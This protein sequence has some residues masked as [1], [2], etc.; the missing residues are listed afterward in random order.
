M[1]GLC[2]LSL[3]AQEQTAPPLPLAGPHRPA[4][5]PAD[6]VITPFGY[7]HPSCVLVLKKGEHR[8]KDGVLHHADGSETQVAPCQYPH[9]NASG[10]PAS[11]SAN[12]R[13]A[14]A[15]ADE[16]PAAEPAITGYV[17][18]AS[19]FTNTSYG[20]QVTTWTV[21]PVPLMHDGQTIFIWPGFQ[22]LQNT[23]SVL[24]PVI[25][26]YN[27]GQWTMASWN[28]CLAGT[29]DESTPVSINPGDAIM[30][31]TEMTCAAGTVTCATWN[32]IIQDL[33]TNQS[34]ELS[35][36][37][38][39]GQTFNWA[40]GGVV[41]VYSVF[42]CYDYPPN[43]SATLTSQLYD[44]NLNL[45]SSPTW[46]DGV[47]SSIS[48]LQPQCNYGVTSTPTQTTLTYGTTGPG[49]GLSGPVTGIAVNQ[50]S[51]ASGTIGITAINGFN[52][53][54]AMTVSNPPTGVTAQITQGSSPTT[55]TLTVTA[56]SAAALTGAN[57][58]AALT[59]TAS[60]PGV[61]TE[62][63]PLNVIVNPPLTGGTGTSVN[64]SSAYNVDG[65]YNDSNTSAITGGLDAIGDVYSAN[66]LSPPG[67]T[68]MGLDFGG[69]QFAFGPP[70]Q[71]DSV[72]GSAAY[73][74]GLPS[75][76]F[77]SL[78]VL[79]TGVNGVQ[80][81]Q[82]VT[83]TY[84]DNATQAFT[85]TFDDWYSGASCTST[86]PCAS[87]ESVADVMPY[88]DNPGGE[89]SGIY[90][91]Y[92]YS[93]PLNSSKTV[94]SLTL[95]TNRKVV[96]LA[97][98]LTNTSSTPTFSPAAGTYTSVQMVTLG[99]TTPAATIYY[100]TN[101]TTPTTASAVYSGPITVSSTTAIQAIA[102]AS[103]YLNSPVASATYTVNIPTA[104]PTFSPAGGTYA[105]VQT[106]TLG[107][108]TPAATIYY[109][110][111]G[112]TPTTSSAVYSGPI[113]VS[114]TTTI[115]AIAVASGYVTSAL[116]SATYTIAIP[117]FS[118]A[119][120]AVTVSPGT[121]GTSTLTIS[122]TNGYAGTVTLACSITASPYGAADIPTCTATPAITLSAT[123]S[124]GTATVAVS[125]T[126][127][128]ASIQPE[129]ARPDGDWTAVTGA[130]L[131]LV[132]LPWISKR[133]R[134]WPALS[135]L[136]F[137]SLLIGSLLGCSSGGAGGGK[138]PS[139]PGTTA[140]NYTISVTG[141]GSDSAHT[142]AT[143]TFTLTVN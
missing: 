81:S 62:T 11:G 89:N 61:A 24:Q 119:A 124:S 25:G 39:D 78:N 15:K 125:S 49:F 57:Q 115:Q 90:Y 94:K 95:P 135:I 92:E 8:S 17:E 132:V 85:Q 123:T 83:V 33:T 104:T 141:T 103:G 5:V 53:S 70:N 101:G 80:A 75:G 66:Q 36:T 52:G 69:I 88:R 38:S 84:T 110:T 136:A 108:A 31:T 107:S 1:L 55:Y 121:T 40:F 93:F 26:S 112:T 116:S 114:S 111:N 138:A 20:K 134:S 16:E 47:G 97:A 41:E 82:I 113:T 100:T 28:C 22:D 14:V 109:T 71:P 139:N 102:V 29:A 30:G 130:V 12:E 64:L 105:S 72:Y 86:N 129:K 140:G 128:T 46:I 91:L 98:T 74:I 118:M 4:G 79:A 45:I 68:P 48:S 73:P 3:V 50:G 63:V 120:T 131:A 142:T 34:T 127:A 43:A 137:A 126:A 65:F 87:G 37:P 77:N 23:I 44:S 56:T 76:Q 58:P 13:S 96:V 2:S 35:A 122:G 117:T 106:V 42:Q 18:N 54:V 67:T 9:F 21:P 7:F 51:S 6:F 19:A 10:V 27:G 59:L 60:S 32:V 143:T 99:S 133:R